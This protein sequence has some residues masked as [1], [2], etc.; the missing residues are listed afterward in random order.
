M[1][2]FFLKHYFKENCEL[3]TKEQI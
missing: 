3:G 1:Y 2:A